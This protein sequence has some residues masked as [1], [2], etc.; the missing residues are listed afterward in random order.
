MSDLNSESAT[1]PLISIL[2]R[3]MA[4]ASLARALE[5]VATQTTPRLEVIVVNASGL[6]HPPL[7]TTCGPYPM[8]LVEPG[9]RLSRSAAANAALA[10]ATGHY[11]L[12]LDDD[13]SIEPGHLH[14]LLG[15]L[16][17]EPAAIAA[18]AG[19]RKINAAGELVGTLDAPW[20]L[21]SLF[22]ENFLPI[23]AVLFDR[24]RMDPST[25][26]DPQFT[27]YEDWD[28]WLQLAQQAHFVHVPGVS[29]SYHLVGGSGLSAEFDY[30]A[31]EAGRRAVYAKWAPRISADMLQ[32]IATRT[33]VLAKNL[34]DVKGRVAD[35]ENSLQRAQQERQVITG[36]AQE[37]RQRHHEAL[38]FWSA[39]QSQLLEVQ[40][41]LGA[42]QQHLVA[43]QQ[44]QHD[45]QARL[46]TLQQHSDQLDRER[47]HMQQLLQE[48]ESLR[49]VLKQQTE[50]VSELDRELTQARAQAEDAAAR[51][52]Q[53]EASMRRAE[54]ELTQILRAYATLESGY[55]Q[56][57]SSVSW[58]VTLPLRK[59]RSAAN[60]EGLLDVARM[61]VR[62]ATRTLPV[63]ARTKQQLK[64]WMVA[65]P[66]AARWMPW[67]A[68]SPSIAP[69]APTTVSAPPPAQVPAAVA[70]SQVQAV[71]H[72]GTLDKEAVRRHAEEQLDDFLASTGRIALPA[73]CPSPTVSVIVV[74]FNQA[75]LSRLCLESLAA[76][77]NVQFETLIVDNAS[78][79][80]TPQLLARVD[81]AH[82][83][84][85][86]ENLG[87]LRAVNLA[88]AQASGKY[89]LLLNNDA[90]VE[91]DTMRHAV[92][93][94]ESEPDAGA[95]GGPILLW[96]GRLQEAGSIVWRDGSCLGYGRGEDPHAPPFLYVRDVDYCSGAFLMTRHALFDALGG[97]DEVFAPAYYEESD[98]C[99]R[100]WEKG[101]RVV[102]DP[103][104][105]VHHFEFASDQGSGRALELQVRNRAHFV[106]RHATFLA[107]RPTPAAEQILRARQRLA[108]A[109]RRV[110]VIDDRVP[111][112]W[113]GQGY[114]RAACIVAELAAAGHAVTHYPLQFPHESREDIARALPE[115][116]EVITD[117]GLAGF[118]GFL[119]ERA[120]YYDLVMVSRPHNMEVLQSV[121]RGH[122][123]W[124]QG[125]RIV[126]DAEALFSLRDI[127]KAALLGRPLPPQEQE[128]RIRAELA[129]ADRA[130]TVVTVSER[131]AQH[132]RQHRPDRPVHVIGHSMM[133]TPGA[134]T[135]AQRAGFLFVGA[136]LHD[137]TPN[138]D[139]LVWF[140]GQVWPAIRA[141]LGTRAELHVV[142]P[143]RSPQVRTLAAADIFLHG[144]SER[145]RPHMDSARVFIVPTR[146]AA[147]IPFKAHE[148]AA[149]GLPLVTTQLIA[150]QLGWEQIV[151]NSDDASIFAQAC[152]E[153]HEDAQRWQQARVEI[154]DAV[155]RDC[156]PAQVRAV[157]SRVVEAF[158]P[159]Q[160]PLEPTSEIHQLP[161]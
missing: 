151:P 31:S 147:G 33:A 89:L 2:V 81:G 130:D 123:D 26:F 5:S 38:Q 17:S 45:N 34:P 148:A 10:A 15:A 83:L 7:P 121:L 125:A 41:D 73:P 110:L 19:V 29:A 150:E 65:R 48:A 124:L 128:L 116:V 111:L 60:A 149:H 87:F 146:Y 141:R 72:D 103:A 25:R 4:R 9:R 88:A 142:G 51:A 85:Q 57:T 49:P 105:R 144:A 139:S 78:S 126:F 79:D 66:W 92:D 3:S 107:E 56:V 21:A 59:L 39:T 138:S 62:S 118:A 90:L 132:Y 117:R 154:L 6:R 114:P 137:D 22:C 11:A 127:A 143:C 113:L 52:A 64:V 20:D 70:L 40:R 156:A 8:H 61:A 16:R 68:L 122:D 153:L 131:E 77:R 44:R 159:V 86:T 100:L 104:V 129:L 140:V 12:F 84:P 109:G 35:L 76:T 18:Y 119:A 101:H 155:E 133:P 71:R 67:L 115:T 98:Y 37:S 95:V 97:F 27:V 112:S 94:L 145:L 46:S 160:V 47:R 93:R 42:T 50:Y 158:S 75:G 82:L 30:L 32:C 13:D 58:R 54:N 152:V 99:V 23:H 106:E 108:P 63:S 134:P 80:H 120:G 43:E 102:Y 96:D 55:G 36:E 136:L 161:V 28:F 69:L 157:V 91:P 1:Y 74:L 24:G 14:R 135:F 53:A